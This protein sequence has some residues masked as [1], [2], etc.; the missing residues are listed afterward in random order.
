VPEMLVWPAF[1]L[2]D[3][4]PPALTSVVGAGRAPGRGRRR[5]GRQPNGPQYPQRQQ[6]GIEALKGPEGDEIRAIC[7]GNFGP[8]PMRPS[9]LEGR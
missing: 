9:E 4:V 7:N 2:R 1:S 8:E 6:V 5:H 3:S